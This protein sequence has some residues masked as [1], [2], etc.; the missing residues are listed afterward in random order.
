M[1]DNDFAIVNSLAEPCNDSDVSVNSIFDS[2]NHH[3]ESET[4]TS[5]VPHYQ[6]YHRFLPH[7]ATKNC[8]VK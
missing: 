7:A 2:D 6:H 8:C 5:L 3:V 1:S 4:Q